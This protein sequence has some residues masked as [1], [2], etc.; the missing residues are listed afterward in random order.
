MK[1]NFHAEQGA[2]IDFEVAL[3]R[4]LS[5]RD[6]F[7]TKYEGFAQGDHLFCAA[8]KHCYSI[9]NILQNITQ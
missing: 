5:Q 6:S 2:V 9:L 7:G 8:P 3:R 1:I 4:I